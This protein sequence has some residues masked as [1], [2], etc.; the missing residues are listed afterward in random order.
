MEGKDLLEKRCAQQLQYDLQVW[1]NCKY[2]L[3]EQSV[4]QLHH[5]ALERM[6][7]K[8]LLEKRHVEKF[9]R[10]ASHERVGGKNLLEGWNAYHG[11]HERMGCKYLL[12]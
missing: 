9:Q 8:D 6:R 5:G 3:E 7:G 12:S 11:L 1:M 2:Q 10:G 4:E